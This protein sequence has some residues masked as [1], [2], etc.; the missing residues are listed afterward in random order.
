MDANK[1]IGTAAID[2]SLKGIHEK[3]AASGHGIAQ[4]CFRESM[5][6]AGRLAGMGNSCSRA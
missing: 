1:C 5:L 6:V 4:L 2:G 3:L